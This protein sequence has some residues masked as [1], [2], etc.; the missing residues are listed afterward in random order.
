MQRILDSWYSPSL[1]KQMEIA[2]YGH[3]GFALLMIP[4]AAADYLEY[5]RFH[6]IDALRPFIDAGKMKVFSI[7]SINAESWLNERIPPRQRSIRHQQYNSYVENEV[8]PY[9]TNA[10]QGRARTITCGV[11]LGALHAA[12]MAFRRPDLFDGTIAMSGVYDL[13]HYTDGYWDEDVY[14]NSP[15]DYLANL[16]EGNALN[17]L[18]SNHQFH[19]LSGSGP[20]EA[21][22]A[23]RALGDILGMKGIPHNVEIWGKEW[24]HDWPTW[25][26]MLPS[27]LGRHF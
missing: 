27:Y 16:R 10:M 24:R 13:K 14:Y 3:Y 6:V 22:W 4:S 15:V 23:A 8:V 21:P 12:N 18:R 26:E 2:V 9:I 5:E 11:S 7:N 1:N 20:Y 17:S 19:I 25:R